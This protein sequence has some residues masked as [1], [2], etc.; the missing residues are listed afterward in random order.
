MTIKQ[1]KA[2]IPNCIKTEA[3]SSSLFTPVTAKAGCST[4]QDDDTHNSLAGQHN[5][6]CW[7][8]RKFSVL[9][10][11]KVLQLGLPAW[12]SLERTHGR[13]SGICRLVSEIEQ[14]WL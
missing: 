6:L 4:C 9:R 2:T 1:P 8:Q 3:R 11:L 12:L 13:A 10:W 5:N 14:K 7:K